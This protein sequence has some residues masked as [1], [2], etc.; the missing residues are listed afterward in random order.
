MYALAGGVLVAAG[1]WWWL[2]RAAPHGPGIRADELFGDGGRLH[3]LDLQVD[4]ER[5]TWLQA[6]ARD[7]EFVPARL[8]FRGREHDAKVR[9]KGNHGT[10][11]GCFDEAGARTCRKLSVK[12]RLPGKGQVKDLVLNS[13]V[14]D[15]SYLRERFGYELYRAT[16]VAAPRTA[17]AE[18][19]VNGEPQG[20]YVLVEAIDRGFAGRSFPGAPGTLLQEIWPIYDRPE[21]YAAAVV[22]RG[23]AAAPAEMV[24]LARTLAAAGPDQFRDR[25]G[26]QVDLEQ[27]IR[28]FAV[29]IFANNIDGPEYF[30]CV[31]HARHEQLGLCVNS[32][33]VW[34]RPADGKLVL[35]PWDLDLVLWPQPT[36]SPRLF[37]P[38]DCAV[39]WLP[40]A[41]CALPPGLDIRTRRLEEITAAG[42]R[43]E[44]RPHGLFPARCDRLLGQALAQLRPQFLIA[45]RGVAA[46]APAV[47][48]QVQLSDEVMA[49]VDRDPAGPHPGNVRS[50]G[51]QLE[52]L[53]Q[54][55]VRYTAALR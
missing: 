55:R 48:R 25:V 24:E 21:P 7:E 47:L 1:V 6:H 35:I 11:R 43:C 5:W 20:L 17:F 2:S 51:R 36:P 41:G 34:Y 40:R 10:L 14:R 46:L 50:A 33:Y 38:G 30:H 52:R 39:E 53:L 32:N 44:A 54:Q 13:S 15:E 45:M 29:S 3:R 23:D 27:L 26:A 12:I 18:L 37:E 9:F 49:A 22:G 16:G 8:R 42:A 19:Y 28:F 31:E 4:A